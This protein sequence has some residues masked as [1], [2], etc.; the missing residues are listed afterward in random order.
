MV[1]TDDVP[2]KESAMSLI[3]FGFFTG[4]GSWLSLMVFIFIGLLFFIPGLIVVMKQ[5][6][7]PK[8]ER[9]KGL[10]IL[11]FIL[12]GIGM[13]IGMGMGLF[14]FSSLLMESIE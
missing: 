1:A 5:N 11:G 13:I 6:N 10:L 14:L 8:E 12:M 9:K 7:K 3:K 2:K 4:L